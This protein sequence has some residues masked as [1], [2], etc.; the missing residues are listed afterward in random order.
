M[1]KPDEKEVVGRGRGKVIKVAK[2]KNVYISPK[3]PLSMRLW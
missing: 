1:H 3:R 2:E